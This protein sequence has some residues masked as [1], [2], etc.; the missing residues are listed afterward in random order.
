MAR[1]MHELVPKDA[2]VRRY[3][4][5]LGASS[6]L[7]GIFFSRNARRVLTSPVFNFLDD[8]LAFCHE[9]D[10]EREG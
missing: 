4:D 2:D 8:I 9:P 10:A 1:F 7:L 6:V 5:S 3:W